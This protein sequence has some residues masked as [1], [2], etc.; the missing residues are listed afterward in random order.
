MEYYL[1]QKD[2]TKRELYEILELFESLKELN[3]LFET[4][5]IVR[6]GGI[7]ESVKKENK[8][9]M[10]KIENCVRV[11]NPIYARSYD[12]LKSMIVPFLL[13]CLDLL[14]KEDPI[15]TTRMEKILDED[16]DFEIDTSVYFVLD[17]FRDIL[18]DETFD[19]A[20]SD[21]NIPLSNGPAP[22]GLNIVTT[23]SRVNTFPVIKGYKKGLQSLLNKE[24]NNYI[25][26]ANPRVP[27]PNNIKHSKRTRKFLTFG[28]KYLLAERRKVNRSKKSRFRNRTN[29]SLT[30]S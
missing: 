8:K 11:F 10:D 27:I 29:G 16:T 1:N 18:L 9:L 28:S 17:K 24:R 15:F 5:L 30:G 4:L 25:T 26:Y 6:S 20:V 14:K 19:V 21:T 2:F 7:L 13:R 3:Y 23:A 22:N 12:T